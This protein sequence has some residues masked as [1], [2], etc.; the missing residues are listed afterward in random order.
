M[1]A[2][3]DLI[4][5][6]WIKALPY[7]LCLIALGGG[8]WYWHNQQGHI[9]TL[10]RDLKQSQANEILSA[11]AADV[12]GIA[13]KQTHLQAE[14][15]DK[16]VVDHITGQQQIT[17]EAA[18][19]IKEINHA[20][21]T[22]DAVVAPV[23]AHALDCLRDQAARSPGGGAVS[24]HQ[25]DATCG[26]YDAAAQASR[27]ET[28]SQ[29]DVARFLIELSAHDDMCLVVVDEIKQWSKTQ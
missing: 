7:L 15:D 12:N 17:A 25:D 27:T 10:E 13:A 6:N 18:L 21:E 8:Y 4:T 1:K 29:A 5:G 24:D 14:A 23:L 22:D 16:A 3:L 9:L 11:G 19:N 26:P 28:Y 2:V 20:P